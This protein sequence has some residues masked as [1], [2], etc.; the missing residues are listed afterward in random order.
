MTQQP[1]IV[2][3]L[4]TRLERQMADCKILI[5]VRDQDAERD[6]ADGCM[7][8]TDARLEKA[9]LGYTIKMRFNAVDE[10]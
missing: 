3:G 9:A 1:A 7:Q 8:H 4:G 10:E 5:R 6:L 2:R